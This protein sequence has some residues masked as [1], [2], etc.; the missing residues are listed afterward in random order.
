M[1]LADAGTLIETHEPGRVAEYLS[2]LH[3]L[4]VVGDDHLFDV[5]KVFFGVQPGDRIAYRTGGE[6]APVL[7]RLSWLNPDFE[8]ACSEHRIMEWE[9]AVFHNSK[10]VSR[11]E[12]ALGVSDLVPS[13][14]KAAASKNPTQGFHR[15]LGRFYGFPECCIDWFSSRD[16]NSRAL[17]AVDNKHHPHIHYLEHIPCSP[18]CAGSTELA[19][20]YKPVRD[21]LDALLAS[22]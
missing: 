14:M 3:E 18:D 8:F 10:A 19:M 20:S 7:A 21:F 5:A 16:M 6:P 9:V 4:E 17:E 11:A 1:S 22:G 13:Y 12:E 15:V 2:E